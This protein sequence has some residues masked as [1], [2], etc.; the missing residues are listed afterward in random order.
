MTRGEKAVGKRDKAGKFA[1]L[2]GSNLDDDDEADEPHEVH[3]P[4]I[5]ALLG[6]DLLN[7]RRGPRTF[8]RFAGRAR[9]RVAEEDEEMVDDQKY[10]ELLVQQQSFLSAAGDDDL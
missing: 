3:L 7:D 10:R 6:G 4:N 1:R 2:G 9:G 5:D 8:D